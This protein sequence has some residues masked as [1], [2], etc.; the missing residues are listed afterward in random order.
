MMHQREYPNEV[1]S[2]VGLWLKTAPRGS[3]KIMAQA[4]GVTTRTVRAWKAKTEHKP[5]GRKKTRVTE[6]QRCEIEHQWKKQGYPGS[7]PIIKALPQISVR[8][9]REVIAS[10]K[11]ETKKRYN[12]HREENRTTVTVHSA[13]TVMVMDA[14]NL[15]D[16]GGDFILRRDRGS[17][18]TNAHKCEGK[19]ATSQDTLQLF[20]QLKEEGRL[21]LVACSDNGS[22]FC[23]NEVED[24]LHDNKIIH[25]KSLPRVPQHNG[26][27]ENSVGDVKKTK[28][29]G[30]TAAQVCQSLNQHR[31]RAKL[32]WKTPLEVEQKTL[33]LHTPEER[34]MFY[35]TARSAI[36]RALL[37]TKSVYEK[38]KAEREAIFQTLESFELITRTR[39]HP[40]RF[41]K[42]EEIT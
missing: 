42:A 22:P 3:Q 34:A 39:G 26:S 38:R 23:A 25:L 40:P 6:A 9:T 17:L 19:D 37:G 4:L 30:L 36:S 21:P 32:N 8:V 35:E 14:A 12:Q 29:F 1:K 28:I 15:K 13:G 5:R 20:K 31:L 2:E 11:E 27:A 33:K 18:T 24:Y 41:V 10:L 7:R 16:E